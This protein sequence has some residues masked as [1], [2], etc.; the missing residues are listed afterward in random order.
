M[1][2]RKCNCSGNC[3]PQSNDLTRR[4]FIRMLSGGA[5]ATL[6]ASPAWGAFELPANQLARWRRELLTPGK[7]LVYSSDRHTD[8]R[9]H[10]GGIG[11]GNF[12]I[13]AEGQLTTWQLFN[14][15]RDGEVPAY[16]IQ[17]G[18]RPKAFA[19]LWRS[20]LAARPAH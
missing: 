19:N 11:T 7:P 17:S 15:L 1:P 6:L 8:A 5:A 9:M 14:T 3:G 2:P 20:Q 4:E 13:G 10:L 16:F 18:G 12:E